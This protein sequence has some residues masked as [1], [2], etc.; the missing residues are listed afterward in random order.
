MSQ[1]G[2]LPRQAMENAFLPLWILETTR[3]NL[4]ISGFQNFGEK[5]YCLEVLGEDFVL[6]SSS[7]FTFRATLWYK[8]PWRLDPH[9]AGAQSFPSD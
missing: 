6:L 2:C 4:R 8:R 3:G 7:L 1:P 5:L 9:T